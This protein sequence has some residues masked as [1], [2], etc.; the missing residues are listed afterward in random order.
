MG[1]SINTNSTLGSSNFDGSI[2][3][4]AKV[5]AT[6][7]YS[8]VGYTG[9]NGNGTIGHGLGVAP[10]AVIVRRRPNASDWAVY[11]GEIGNSKR[12]V[13]NVNSGESN[14]SAGWWQNT[15]PTSSVVYLGNDAGLNG[16]TDT[17]IAY[18]FSEVEGYS[19][20]G[21][22]TG[23][24]SNNGRFVFTG[25]KVK[26][27]LI[28]KTNTSESWILA[29]SKRNSNVGRKSPADS[30]LLADSNNAESTGIIYDLNSNGFKFRST[31]QN[32]SGHTYVYFAFAE[33]PFRNARAT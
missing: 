32:T 33:S 4:T 6:A 20:F 8:I 28:K 2:Q 12:L 7:G 5:N 1:S 19:K 3:T 26:W 29:D 18:C 17:Y 27:L 23:N 13:L 15:S 10:K 9:T 24:G 21:K 22:Y 30:Y 14:S 31:S 11:H 16:T 25:F